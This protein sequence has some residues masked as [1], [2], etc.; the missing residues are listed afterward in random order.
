[1][2]ECVQCGYHRCRNVNGWACFHRA[3]KRVFEA[4]DYV[5]SESHS[6]TFRLAGVDVRMQPARYVGGEFNVAPRWAVATY[7]R[8]RKRGEPPRVAI[9]A[10]LK[11]KPDAPPFDFSEVDRLSAMMIFRGW[12]HCHG[13]W[14]RPK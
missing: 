11:A 7:V 6:K 13:Y 10:A 2:S 14:L 8:A 4:A 1:M 3:C 12:T 9:Q 5:R